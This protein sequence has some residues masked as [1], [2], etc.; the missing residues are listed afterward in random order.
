MKQFANSA[1]L[2]NYMVSLKLLLKLEFVIKEQRRRYVGMD[3]PL[4]LGLEFY[5][6][7]FLVVP[8][9]I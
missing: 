6:L 3:Q 1:E 7:G 5:N 2:V 8:R 4:P 9:I